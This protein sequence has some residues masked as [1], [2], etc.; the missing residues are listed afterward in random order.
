MGGSIFWYISRLSN[1]FE[2]G[3]D[4]YNMLDAHVIIPDGRALWASS[5]PNLLWALRGGGGN[6]GGMFSLKISFL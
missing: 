1:E 6:F 2:L 5:E 3:S 4:P